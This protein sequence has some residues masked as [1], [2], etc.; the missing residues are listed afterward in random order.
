M[1]SESSIKIATRSSKLALLQTEEVIKMLQ[2]ALPYQSFEIITHRSEGD[3]NKSAPLSTMK[4]GMFAKGIEQI[5]LDGKA[6]VAVHSAK[7]V[8]SYIPE[9]LA[10]AGFSRRLDPRDVLVGNIPASLSRLPHGASLGT[11]SQR[12]SCQLLN[13]R[14]DLDIVSVRGNVDS[15]LKLP[16]QGVVHAVVLAAAGI[17]R[18]GRGQEISGYLSIEESIP[19]VGQG[20]LI[21]ECRDDETLDLLQGIGHVETSV[22][23]TAER[24]FLAAIEGGCNSPVAAHAEMIGAELLLR[25]MAGTADGK[26]IY[27]S[28]TRAHVSDPISAG[29]LAAQNLLDVGAWKM[30]KANL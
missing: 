12:R 22:A 14:P 23:V 15:R 13:A 20:A 26:E 27:R 7:D 1:T 8:P 25:T 29:K 2:L 19:D 17:E 16:S 11:S 30:Y 10:I 6:D 24:A 4:R 5:L 3:I 28:E 9:G 21:V 18:L